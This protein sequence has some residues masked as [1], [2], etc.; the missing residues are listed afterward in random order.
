MPVPPGLAS[1]VVGQHSPRDAVQP[2]QRL[3][4]WYVVQPP[5]GDQER[6]GHQVGRVLA[7]VQ[8]AYDVPQYGIVM[9]G[10]QAPNRIASYPG[11]CPGPAN[12]YIKTSR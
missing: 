1:A 7:D 3:L 5:P 9:G 2:R 4:F 10:E 8:T 12:S 11:L 6:L